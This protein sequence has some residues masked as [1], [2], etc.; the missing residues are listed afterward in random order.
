MKLT[1]EGNKDIAI[2][3]CGRDMLWCGAPVNVLNCKQ[4]VCSAVMSSDEG[5]S[6]Y[7]HKL[8]FYNKYVYFR[9]GQYV[10]EIAA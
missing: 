6:C 5:S 1:V 9:P 2:A 4:V 7:R 3:C 8:Y 10:P